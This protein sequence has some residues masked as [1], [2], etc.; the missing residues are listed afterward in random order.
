MTDTDLAPLGPV[1]DY[2]ALADAAG[3]ARQ[4][5]NER[6]QQ[7]R[8]D[9]ETAALRE[10]VFTAAS[11]GVTTLTLEPSD[12]GD[13]MTVSEIEPEVSGEA[14]DYIGD[15][16]SMDMSDYS[17]ADWAGADGVEVTEFSH[18][19]DQIRMATIDITVA[20][21]AFLTTTD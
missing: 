6:F 5:A 8:A 12:Q 15:A 11:Y 21:Q 19:D 2:A 16:G 9:S 20:A 1:G 4:E 13:Y 18:R 14:E 3:K 17:H 10:L 7:A